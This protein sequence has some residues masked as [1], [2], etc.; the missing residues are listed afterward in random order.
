MTYDPRTLSV[1]IHAHS[2]I[3]K[4]TLTGSAPRPII[5][6]DAE[7]GSKFLASSEQLAMKY[8]RWPVIIPWDPAGPPPRWDGTWDI[9]LVTVMEWQNLVN[10]RMWLEQGQHDFVTVDV[11][12]ISEIQRRLKKN[13]VGTESMKQQ[14]WGNLLTGM[15]DVIR[16]L[17]DLTINPYN[18]I[19]VA[20]FVAETRQGPDGK[21]R[22]YMQGQIQTAL[23]YWMD[24]VGYLYTDMMLD[25]QGQPTVEVR[26][27]LVNQHPSY[28]AGQRVQGRV[29][30]VIDDPDISKILDAVYPHYQPPQTL[31]TVTS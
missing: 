27:L 5:K 15:D 26:K 28:E 10:A 23:P 9:A 19:R 7:G 3:G 25:A 16:G 12:S 31:E 30:P 17:R 6:F 21:W 4:T 2:K 24:I 29:G 13:L 14:D 18:P 20:V 1:L 22:P 11:D 8:G